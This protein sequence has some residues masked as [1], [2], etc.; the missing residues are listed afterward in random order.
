VAVER[1]ADRETVMTAAQVHEQNADQLAYWSGAAGQRWVDRQ[2]TL[3]TILAPI[4]DILLDRAAVAAGE[5]VIDVGC[6]CGASAI[7]LAGKVGPAG[8]VTGIDISGPMLARARERTAPDLPLDLVLADATVHPFE[9]QRADLLASRFGVMFFADPA[10][11]F[12]NTRTALRPGGRVAFACWREPARNPWMI[13]PLQEAYRFVPKLPEIGPEDPG[14]FAFA[15]EE[16]VRGILGEA[17]FSSIAMEPV[18]LALDV[19]LGRG[20]DTAVRAAIDV[21][22]VRRALE[23]QPPDVMSKLEGALRTAL[24][25]FQNGDTVPLGASVWIVTALSEG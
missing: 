15:R 12:R 20:L 10:A 3:D 24:A 14:P 13:L 9:P 1:A 11:S 19:G 18:D 6:G 23:G 17:G 4:L 2:E 5:R 7:A 16:R 22:P 21:G 25:P 8:R